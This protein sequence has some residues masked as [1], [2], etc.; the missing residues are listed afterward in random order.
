[1]SSAN[2]FRILCFGDSLTAGYH[3][4]G[5]TF[6]PYGQFL[7][8]ALGSSASVT[9]VGFSGWTTTQLVDNADRDMESDVVG[10][11]WPGLKVALGRENFNLAIVMGGTNDLGHGHGPEVGNKS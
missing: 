5:M 9:I 8:E 7:K 10:R 4:Y 1:M 11:K 3:N 2:V 6:S